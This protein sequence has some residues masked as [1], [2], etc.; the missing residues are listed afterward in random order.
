MYSPQRSY[1]VSGITGTVGAAL[2]QDSV[3]F[4]MLVGPNA[5]LWAFPD[6]IR[7]AFTT[8]VAFTTPVTAG[9]RL[10]VHR[11]TGGVA[12]TGGAALG[13]VKKKTGAPTSVVTDVRIATTVALGIAGITVLPD[14]IAMLDLTAFGA[15]G[16]RAERIY[17]FNPASYVPPHGIAP[18]ELLVVKTPAVFDAVGTWQLAAD[19]HWTEN[20]AGQ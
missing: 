20:N 16:G 12:A 18:G 15:A 9:R 13:V 2:A 6:A 7:L 10:T 3:V 19:V 14:P 17:E 8:I 11:A 4:A 5:E 1:E